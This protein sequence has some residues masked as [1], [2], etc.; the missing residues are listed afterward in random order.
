MLFKWGTRI[1]KIHKY[2]F[3]LLKIKDM[4]FLEPPTVSLKKN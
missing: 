4:T 1:R 3:K 2:L